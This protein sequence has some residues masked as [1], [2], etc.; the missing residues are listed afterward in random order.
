M[1]DHGRKNAVYLVT[2]PEEF[3]PERPWELPAQILGGELYVKNI[4]LGHALGFAGAFNKRAMELGLPDRKWAIPVRR[5]HF[6]WTADEPDLEG[7]GRGNPAVGVAK[8]AGKG[9]AK[10]AAAAL[11][12]I[13]EAAGDVDV[14]LPVGDMDLT[15]ASAVLATEGGAL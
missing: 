3:R 8:R 2:V 9:V 1:S 13:G 15:D 11:A 7:N 5:G 4:I 10:G 6:F 14:H 12:T